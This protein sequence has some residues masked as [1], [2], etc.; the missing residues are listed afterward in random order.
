M[1]VGKTSDLELD[2][3]A[4]GTSDDVQIQAAINAVTSGGGGVVKILAGVYDIRST[5]VIPKDPK[6]RVEGE[7]VTKFGYGGTELRA[8]SGLGTNL[9]AIIK[10]AGNLVADTSNADHSHASQYSRIIFNGNNKSDVGL[11]LYN[12]DHT[13]VSD[14]KFTGSPSI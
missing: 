1:T 8:Y 9:E 3:I 4:D 6:L 11:L 13:I 7:Y 12:T 2:Y 14:C 5:I 10:E